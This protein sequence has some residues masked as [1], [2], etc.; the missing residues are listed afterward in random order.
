M[1]EKKAPRAGRQPRR[2][3][4]VK[5]QVSVTPELRDAIRDEAEGEGLSVSSWTARELE[6]LMRERKEGR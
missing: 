5:L 6:R 1:A 4:L 2:G 3:D